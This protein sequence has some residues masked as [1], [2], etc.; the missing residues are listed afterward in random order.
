M[1]FTAKLGIVD[2]QLNNIVLGLGSSPLPYV[3]F[4][5]LYTLVDGKTDDTLYLSI[6]YPSS[7]KVTVEIPNPFIESSL[8][9]EEPTTL[10]QQM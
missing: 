9:G 6:T 3:L 2:S 8:I 1:A 7:I 5:G 4:S 10:D